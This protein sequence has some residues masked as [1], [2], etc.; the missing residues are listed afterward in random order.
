MK[1]I[2]TEYGL[3]ESESVGLLKRIHGQLIRVG[4]VAIEHA[5]LAAGHAAACCAC[6]AAGAQL[7]EEMFWRGGAGE[8]A[9]AARVRC[10]AAH[11]ALRLLLKVVPLRVEVKVPAVHRANVTLSSLSILLTSNNN[12]TYMR[13]EERERE[14]ERERALV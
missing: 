3:L 8:G 13:W 6:A 5:K 4:L 14:R 2:W 11:L 7:V 10:G 9:D 1:Q 12:Y